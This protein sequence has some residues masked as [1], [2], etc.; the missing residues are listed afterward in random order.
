MSERADTVHVK[1]IR[2][3]LCMEGSVGG[4]DI[5][6]QRQRNYSERR[7]KR[8]NVESASKRREGG[9]VSS[10]RATAGGYYCINVV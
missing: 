2:L 1:Q 5:S 9:V 10:I 8:K 6:V 7:K 4:T 3:S